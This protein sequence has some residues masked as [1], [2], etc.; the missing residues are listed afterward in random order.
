MVYCFDSSFATTY[1]ILPICRPLIM[2]WNIVLVILLLCSV[3]D[4]EIDLLIV[5]LL[6]PLPDFSP[7]P[8]PLPLSG[9]GIGVFRRPGHLVAPLAARVGGDLQR[10]EVAFGGQSRIYL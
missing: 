2:S 9:S 6:P 3:I 7:T 8:W 10:D 5:L 4:P 1:F